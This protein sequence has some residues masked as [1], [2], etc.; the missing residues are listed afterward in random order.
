M[1]QMLSIVISNLQM[2]TLHH[3]NASKSVLSPS[4]FHS[5]YP[6]PSTSGDLGIS[7]QKAETIA[8]LTSFA[9]TP[10]LFRLFFAVPFLLPLLLSFR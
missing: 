5:F 2:F 1:L 10:F 3:Q 9:G 8:Y 4:L 7:K 6:F